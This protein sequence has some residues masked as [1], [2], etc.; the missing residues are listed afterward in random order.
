[1]DFRS[2]KHQTR[3]PHGDGRAQVRGS[4]ALARIPGESEMSVVREVAGSA[5]AA[6]ALERSWRNPLG[7]FGW[8]S[9]TTHQ[10]IGMRYIV[11]AF[12]FLVIGGVEALLMWTQRARADSTF[13]SPDKYN[14]IF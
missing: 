8:L 6:E 9:Y 4:G 3:K 12:I 14:Q 5:E 1:M 10:A 7:I 11:T 2:A 13:L